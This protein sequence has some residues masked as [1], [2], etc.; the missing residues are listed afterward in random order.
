MSRRAEKGPG[1]PELPERP[2][3]G[4]GRGLPPGRRPFR[5]AVGLALALLLPACAP[6]TAIQSAGT[7]QEITREILWE[8]RKHPA[9]SDVR[10]SCSNNVVRLEGR[11]PD[12]PA[13]ELALR[14]AHERCRSAQVEDRLGVRPR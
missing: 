7:D 9:L 13:H 14:I 11:V 4:S 3:E 1:H 12:R 8:Y 2:D 10:V 5:W 6:K